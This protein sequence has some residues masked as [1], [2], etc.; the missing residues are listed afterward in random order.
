MLYP[1][2]RNIPCQEE[3]F[4]KYCLL[5]VPTFSLIT[6]TTAMTLVNKSHAPVVTNFGSKPPPSALSFNLLVKDSF[7][8]VNLKA[9]LLDVRS[10]KMFDTTSWASATAIF[11]GRQRSW[12]LS[13]IVFC[14]LN[15]LYTVGWCL[16]V[17]LPKRISVSMNLC[18][19]HVGARVISVSTRAGLAHTLT[20]WGEWPLSQRSTSSSSLDCFLDTV[21][22]FFD[23][24]GSWAIG[25]EI[26]LTTPRQCFFG[27]REHLDF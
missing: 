26:I 1:Q 7:I 6:A 9:L 24:R 22:S 23:L 18:V 17:L 5:K 20:G 25:G 27:K 11:W 4:S 3:F 13:F 19:Y 10:R 14:N 12:G 15:M 16:Y 21:K 2:P 8:S